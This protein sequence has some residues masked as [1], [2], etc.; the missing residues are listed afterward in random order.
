MRMCGLG[1][2]SRLV[3]NRPISGLNSHNRCLGAHPEV[4]GRHHT[5]RL[6]SHPYWFATVPAPVLDFGPVIDRI[7]GVEVGL[8]ETIS[9]KTMCVGIHARRDRIVVRKRLHRID[10]DQPLGPHTR[11]RNAVE[12]GRLEKVHVVV[13]ESVQ[14]DQ[15]DIRRIHVLGLVDP[16]GALGEADAFVA[17]RAG[18]GVTLRRGVRRGDTPEHQRGHEENTSIVHITS[19]V[20]VIQRY[21]RIAAGSSSM[22]LSVARNFDPCAPSIT[23]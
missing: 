20:E 1:W 22:A 5:L 13:P 6:G 18:V 19:P 11:S 21:T 10:R 7:V 4:R 2:P 23:R 3:E 15:H 8:K 16:T 9:D 14:G 12:V 17:H